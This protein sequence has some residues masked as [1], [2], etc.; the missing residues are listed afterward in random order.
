VVQLNV[1]LDLMSTSTRLSVVS[2]NY[3]TLY[4]DGTRAA[5]VLKSTC[6][7]HAWTTITV[8]PFFFENS[9]STPSLRASCFEPMWYCKLVKCS[10]GSCFTRY[11]I[12]YFLWISIIFLKLKTYISS[13]RW[14]T[15]MGNLRHGYGDMREIFVMRRVSGSLP[16]RC[17]KHG[18][19]ATM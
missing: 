4:N 1:F 7:R 18:N 16:Q 13:K 2:N 15:V 3:W 11:L 14:W 6:G 5:K 17:G 9:V 8:S 12:A 19:R 10:E